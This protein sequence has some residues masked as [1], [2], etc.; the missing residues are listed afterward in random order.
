MVS[1]VEDGR[2][3]SAAPPSLP[4]ETVVDSTDGS[5]SN[6]I[7]VAS[8]TSFASVRRRY[9]GSPS[10]IAKAVESSQSSSRS[11]TVT[12][13]D[14]AAKEAAL[15]EAA[16]KEALARE[17]AAKRLRESVK[18]AAE[19]RAAAATSSAPPP[20]EVADPTSLTPPTQ[21]LAPPYVEEEEEDEEAMEFPATTE[22]LR[23][24]IEGEMGDMAIKPIVSADDEL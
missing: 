3:A 4:M 15:K 14:V 1:V 13:E 18:R 17:A 24:M 7:A 5:P 11:S 19:K 22:E 6:P 9:K 12:E 21:D 8:E 2:S 10:A 23:V 16:V 20:P